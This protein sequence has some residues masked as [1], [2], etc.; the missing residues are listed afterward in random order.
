M[1]TKKTA[2][3]TK[4]SDAE[5]S[6]LAEEAKA[7]LS[8]T[9]DVAGLKIE[10]ARKRLAAALER[11]KELQAERVD[12]ASKQ[13]QAE[14]KE[15]KDLASTTLDYVQDLCEHAQEDVMERAKTT[16]QHVRANPYQAIG[17]ALGVGVLYGYFRARRRD[18][19]RK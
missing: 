17:I 9:T 18:R 1:T 14:F 4:A 5:F 11:E 2:N 7:L 10:R 15:L 12:T 3:H 6:D 19:H 13:V 16:D 8:A